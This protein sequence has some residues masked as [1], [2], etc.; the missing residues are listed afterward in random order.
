MIQKRG[1]VELAVHSVTK[2]GPKVLC[3]M[4]AI[5][6]TVCR[7]GRELMMGFEPRFGG[8]GVRA[9]NQIKT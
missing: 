9:E 2:S 6:L 8:F 5:M 1:S 7:L 4:A 3:K